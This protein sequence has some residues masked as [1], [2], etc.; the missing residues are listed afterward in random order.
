MSELRRGQSTHSTSSEDSKNPKELDP[1]VTPL[2]KNF[3]NVAIS[4]GNRSLSNK[5][6]T[7]SPVKTMSFNASA[8]E[9]KKIPMNLD[10][11]TPSSPSDGENSEFPP[12]TEGVDR[13]TN[14]VTKNIVRPKELFTMVEN[15]CKDMKSDGNSSYGQSVKAFT[16]AA[17]RN[18]WM[19]KIAIDEHMTC[20]F[21]IGIFQYEKETCLL[22]IQ[23]LSGEHFTFSQ[24]LED[25]KSIL[26]Q[27]QI[28]DIPSFT[29]EF[30]NSYGLDMEIS[31]EAFS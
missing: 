28:V 9:L 26:G 11:S 4:R 6:E 13:F 14:F 2:A 27:R 7:L 21:S 22:D 19:C 20:E 12:W 25:F 17:Y 8:E 18:Y 15:I 30:L 5:D 24:F 29:T 3:R 23:E 31:L 10:V 16:F 1:P